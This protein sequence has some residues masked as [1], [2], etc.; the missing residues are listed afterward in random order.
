MGR[1]YSNDLRRRVYGDISEGQSCRASA[2]RFGVSASTGVRLAARMARTGSL[3]P[4]RQGRPPGKGKLTA[5]REVL[6]GWVE[7]E[8]DISMAELAAKLRDRMQVVV[9]P[10]SLSR[11]LLAAGF[12][13]KKNP[14][15]DRE[16]T[17]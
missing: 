5:Y 7:M 4:G 17:R 10:G 14:A 16:R 13:F 6:I 11:F 2:R 12:T 1:A 8:P 9:H 3:E 15:G